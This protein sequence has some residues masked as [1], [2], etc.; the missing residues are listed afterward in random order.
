MF[1]SAFNRLSD[2]PTK[3]SNTLKQLKHTQHFDYAS[4]VNFSKS[5]FPLLSLFLCVK[6][7]FIP[8][9]LFQSYLTRHSP[10]ENASND[11]QRALKHQSNSE[12]TWDLGHSEGT[13]TLADLSQSGS[14]TFSA[15]RHLNTKAIRALRYSKQTQA[16]N[17]LYLTESAIKM[18]IPF[19][20]HIPQYIYL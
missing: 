8:R 5:S 17:A 6:H 4:E 9:I 7:L 2:N 15:L 3:W 10:T 1:G 13:W 14:Q 20:I 11:T 19:W 18:H 12:N 16:L